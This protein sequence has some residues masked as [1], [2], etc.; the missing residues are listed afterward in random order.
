M[1]TAFEISEA[2]V[3][4]A[5]NLRVPQ[6]SGNFL[7][8]WVTISFWSWTLVPGVCY[9]ESRAICRKLRTS[10]FPSQETLSY[11]QRERQTYKALSGSDCR[12]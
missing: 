6:K 7:T 12:K 2:L 11:K 8:S 5:M 4:T 1:E 10:E 9:L 3:N